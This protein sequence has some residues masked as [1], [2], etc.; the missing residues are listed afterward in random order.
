VELLNP[1]LRLVPELVSEGSREL[2]EARPGHLIA[3]LVHHDHRQHA[4][5]LVV[6]RSGNLAEGCA[7]CVAVRIESDRPYARHGVR[8]RDRV[9]A[10]SEIN[11]DLAGLIFGALPVVV[12]ARSAS[13]EAR[14]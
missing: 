2:E 11:K 7:H 3:V 14:G 5:A 1:K 4:S 10:A 13:V 8:V 12:G 9:F 6:L